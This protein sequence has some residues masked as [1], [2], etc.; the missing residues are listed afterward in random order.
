MLRIGIDIDDTLCDF[1]GACNEYVTP[2]L[3]KP[4][5]KGDYVTIKYSYLWKKSESE[6]Q[7][8]IK[9]FVYSSIED[10]TPFPYSQ[11]CLSNCKKS[12]KFEFYAITWKV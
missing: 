11:E 7:R 2:Y 6:S 5:K 12:G 4:L 10:L 8:L 3:S 9:E 1:T